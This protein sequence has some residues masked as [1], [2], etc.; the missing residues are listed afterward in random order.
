MSELPPACLDWLAAHHGV[1]D[2]R[3]LRRHEVGRSTLI[4]LLDAGVLRKAA[5]SVFVVGTAPATFEQRCAIQCAA[6]PRGFITGPTAGTLAGL[7]RMPRTAPV[8]V[9]VLHGRHLP[10]TPGVTWRQ[11]TA[12][13]RGDRV[14][15]NGIV[16]ASWSRLAFDLA[17]DHER[18]DHL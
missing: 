10:P 5:K 11:T 8:H 6:H 13:T 4:R 17:A 16:V 1:I 12:I 15:R 7:R 9:A 14:E 18:L 2:V 3:T